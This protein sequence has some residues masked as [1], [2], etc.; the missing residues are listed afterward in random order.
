MR[1]YNANGLLRR[2]VRTYVRYIIYYTIAPRFYDGSGGGIAAFSAAQKR[3][4]TFYRDGGSAQLRRVRV[5]EK[6]FPA[7]RDINLRD[8]KFLHPDWMYERSDDDDFVRVICVLR[9]L[10]IARIIVGRVSL[11]KA[12]SRSDSESDQLDRI[13]SAFANLSLSISL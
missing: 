1:F 4:K 9:R 6:T 2:Y 12:I 3:N 13:Y 5:R 8:N 7:G 10:H 11:K